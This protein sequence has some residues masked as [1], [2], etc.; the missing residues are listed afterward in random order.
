MEKEAD[1]VFVFGGTN[2]YGH[3]DADIGEK[4]SR[5]FYTFYGAI[6]N[7]I[8]YMIDT[9]GKDKLCFILP[10]HRCDEV[11][12]RGKA[13]KEFVEILR[14]ALKNN[15]VDFLDF[16]ENGLPMPTSGETDKYFCDGL[17]PNDKG[18]KW[19]ADRVCE[20]L[21]KRFNA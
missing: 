14:M 2:D 10:L 9:Y 1:F 8:L 16:F 17:H 11:G 12:I 6:N 5:D 19:I 3:G 4:N 7:L 18:H 15:E 21:E 20:Y 13:L